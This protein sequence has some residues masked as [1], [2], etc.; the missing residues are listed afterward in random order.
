MDK[1]YT[2]TRRKGEEERTNIYGGESR[3]M[4]G[5]GR[6]EGQTSAVERVYVRR[7]RGEKGRTNT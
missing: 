2:R 1:V 4:R 7:M 6:G 3:H 5:R